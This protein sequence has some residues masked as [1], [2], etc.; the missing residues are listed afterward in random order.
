M[1][2]ETR[3]SRSVH[4]YPPS[5]QGVVNQALLQKHMVLY[6]ISATD[7]PGIKVVAM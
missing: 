6:T 3:P 1:Q 4:G 5:N 7:I 2:G